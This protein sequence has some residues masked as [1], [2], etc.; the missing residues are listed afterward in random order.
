MFV[1]VFITLVQKQG[2]R[3]E[4]WRKD[5]TGF[6]MFVIKLSVTISACLQLT[7]KN[8]MFSELLLFFSWKNKSFQK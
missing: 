8:L 2:K 7:Q 6:H 4:G 5:L 1:N 3:G